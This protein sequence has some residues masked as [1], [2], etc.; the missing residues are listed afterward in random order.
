MK[1]S[2]FKKPYVTVYLAVG[3]SLRGPQ[4]NAVTYSRWHPIAEI[5]QR[6]SKSQDS[7]DDPGPAAQRCGHSGLPR[8]SREER[9]LE[10]PAHRLPAAVVQLDDKDSQTPKPRI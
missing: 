7:W 8:A 6:H 4:N 1:N 2:D 10:A 3:F 9:V 5:Q